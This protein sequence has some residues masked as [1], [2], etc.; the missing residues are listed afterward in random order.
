MLALYF[1]EEMGVDVERTEIITYAENKV[2]VKDLMLPEEDII[3]AID[4]ARENDVPEKDVK[5]LNYIFK[6]YNDFEV[7][8]IVYD[9]KEQ[10]EFAS[11]L[12]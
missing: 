4:K 5:R 3:A 2:P 9:T 7:D 12:V 8:I 10:A 11:F 6:V 1:P